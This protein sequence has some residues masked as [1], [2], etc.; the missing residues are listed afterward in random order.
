MTL[1]ELKKSVP[2]TT[3]VPQAAEIMGVSPKFI[4]AALI[5]GKFP[6]GIAVKMDQNEFYINTC[7]FLIYMEGEDMKAREREQSL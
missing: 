7:R 4:R 3:T 6:F 1:E 5:Q 2:K